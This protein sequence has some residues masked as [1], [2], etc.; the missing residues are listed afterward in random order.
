MTPYKYRKL[1]DWRRIIIVILTIAFIFSLD[2][3]MPADILREFKKKDP[4]HKN[5][6]LCNHCSDSVNRN[7]DSLA[8]HI[9]NICQ[10][11]G[12]AAHRYDAKGKSL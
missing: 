12:D 10:A 11:A 2:S 4:N 6:K 5:R 1:L 3:K 7:A 9:I 8:H